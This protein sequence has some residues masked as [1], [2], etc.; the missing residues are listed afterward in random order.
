MTNATQCPL[1]FVGCG[2]TLEP[3]GATVMTCACNQI[4]DMDFPFALYVPNQDRTWTAP[5][6]GAVTACTPQVL[7]VTIYNRE[8]VSSEELEATFVGRLELVPSGA[9]N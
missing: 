2:P 8:D 7:L 5:Q 4:V 6:F 9:E 1:F 3:G